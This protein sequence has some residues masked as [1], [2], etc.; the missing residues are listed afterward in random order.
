MPKFT[1]MALAWEIMR[2][3]KA[4][5]DDCA[6]QYCVPSISNQIMPKLAATSN[7]RQRR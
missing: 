4:E 5:L 1:P 7:I 2:C 6:P 3:R